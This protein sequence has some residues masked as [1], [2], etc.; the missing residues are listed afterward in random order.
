M[1]QNFKALLD[2]RGTGSRAF[3]V[4]VAGLFSGL[5]FAPLSVV[6]FWPLAGALTLYYIFNS[7]TWRGRLAVSFLFNYGSMLSSLY[8]ISIAPTVDPA[9]Y[10]LIP[11]AL[12]LLPAFA[13]TFGTA[14]LFIAGFF[15]HTPIAFAALTASSW[16]FFEW[17]RSI[18]LTGFSWNR[19]GMIWA[20]DPTALQIASLGGIPLL[21]FIT[22]VVTCA[23][24]LMLSKHARLG[25]W[26]LAAIL[27][28]L[29]L[30]GAIRLWQNPLNTQA[31]IEDVR[32]RLVQANIPKNTL[33]GALI[34]EQHLELSLKSSTE[35]ISHVIWP[36]GS[37]RDFL[38]TNSNLRDYISA[39]LSPVPFSLI[40]G[41]RMADDNVL[42]LTRKN[43]HLSAYLIDN[44]N[45][46]FDTYDKVKLVPFGEYI[47]YESFFSWLGFYSLTSQFINRLPGE[48]PET[49][50]LSSGPKIGVMI[51]YD[52]LNSGRIVNQGNRPDFLVAITEDAWFI[53]SR[54]K[55][56]ART[57]GPYQHL[58]EARIR[59]VEEGLSIARSSNPGVTGVIDPLG[60]IASPTLKL[61]DQGFLDKSIPKALKPTLYS[62][63]GP[64]LIY[65][66]LCILP[67]GVF[68]LSIFR[69]PT[70]A[71][72]EIS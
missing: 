46:A 12:F 44:S 31:F 37:T 57:P 8:W 21:S 32:V 5:S 66:S 36:E 42:N 71:R 70:R 10:F 7:T 30:F 59:A 55:L 26:V 28:P 22:I 69:S 56:L 54:S 16:M 27:V 50:S 58:S 67:L 17:R 15:R 14:A 60:R 39:E 61:N 49:L 52:S 9:F 18:D 53:D 47:P 65:V 45:S 38:D 4:F 33:S 23:L 48:G 29:H 11:F 6:F 13:A 62:S 19:A 63:F 43:A 41:R 51:C 2:S 35:G 1:I 34:L 24:F 3:L 20:E 64:N 25:G 68:A 40:F 72:R